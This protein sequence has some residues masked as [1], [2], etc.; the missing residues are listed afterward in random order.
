MAGDRARALSDRAWTEICTA[1]R[2][3][4]K[5]EAEVR[6]ELSAI[7]LEYLPYADRREGVA[8]KARLAK[9]MLKHLAAFEA[10]HR[11]LFPDDDRAKQDRNRLDS[12]RLRVET[13]KAYARTLRGANAGKRDPQRARS[14]ARPF[15]R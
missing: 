1:A 7:L 9:R 2:R 14:M 15:P 8:K 5:R 12:L 3:K 4:P 10:D 13:M 11:V 6:A